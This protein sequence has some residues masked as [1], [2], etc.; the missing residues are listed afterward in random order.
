MTIIILLCITI[1][2]SLTIAFLICQEALSPIPNPLAEYDD[3]DENIDY[4][5]TRFEF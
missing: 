5:A 4:I 2:F 3:W 1:L